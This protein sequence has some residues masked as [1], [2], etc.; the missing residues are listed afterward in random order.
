MLA[1]TAGARVTSEVA[2]LEGLASLP[3]KVL[4][5]SQPLPSAPPQTPPHS[6]E[7]PD[8]QRSAGDSAWSPSEP[9]ND[10]RHAGPAQAHSSGPVFAAPQDD[11]PQQQHVHQQ[12]AKVMP[13]PA[14]LL[15]TPTT[16]APP[17]SALAAG[18]TPTASPMPGPVSAHTAGQEHWPQNFADAKSEASSCYRPIGSQTPMLVGSSQVYRSVIRNPL[19][20]QLDASMLRSC[21]AICTGHASL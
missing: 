13:L 4:V 1:C 8:Q 15:S 9:A 7:R 21:F 11:S 19:A 14:P 2:R 17:V 3:A 20:R 16:Q 6:D 18:S 10:A 5:G 12:T